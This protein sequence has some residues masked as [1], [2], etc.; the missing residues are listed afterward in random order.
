MRIYLLIDY[1]QVA[2][3]RSAVMEANRSALFASKP[4]MSAHTKLPMLSIQS[5][6]Q[7]FAA[8]TMRSIT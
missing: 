2:R 6:P 3:R 7:K 4:A 1:L 5:S 8:K